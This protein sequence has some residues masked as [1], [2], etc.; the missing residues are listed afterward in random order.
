MKKYCC[1]VWCYF[2]RCVAFLLYVPLLILN[3]NLN[4]LEIHIVLKGVIL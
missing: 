2:W 1:S 4:K 3:W